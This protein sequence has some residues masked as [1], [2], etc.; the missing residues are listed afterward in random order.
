VLSQEKPGTISLL[1]T[2]ER[3]FL[4]SVID[5]FLEA[6]RRIQDALI[7]YIIR[8]LQISL[9]LSMSDVVKRLDANKVSLPEEVSMPLLSY[10]ERSG[11]LLKEYRDLSQHSAITASEPRVLI[12]KEGVAGI[13]F[14]IANNPET[15]SSKSL[16]FTEPEIPAFMF[17]RTQFYHLVS[18]T[19]EITR[20]LIDP[21]ET[22]AI[23]Y[24]TGV[25]SPL[26]IGEGSP[27]Y[28]APLAPEQITC[29]LTELLAG[30]K[31]L[32]I[33]TNH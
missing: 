4:G 21:E 9:P 24:C 23:V 30:L 8:G 5:H 33:Q 10:W 20:A 13:S 2:S 28:Y 22:R 6:A 26:V 29:E 17:I 15:K 25:F 14:I 19:D 3:N 27:K 31:A 7:S 32:V 16:R 11:R 1:S 12:N 18:I